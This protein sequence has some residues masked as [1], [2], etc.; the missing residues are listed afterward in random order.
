MR[1][2]VPATVA[3]SVTMAWIT[4]NHGQH[5]GPVSK[6]GTARAL[7]ATSMGSFRDVQVLFGAK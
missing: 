1:I 7:E 2:W 3:T 5:S 4:F 6:Q